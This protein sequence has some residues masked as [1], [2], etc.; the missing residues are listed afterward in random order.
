[1]KANKLKNG[2]LYYNEEHERVER[3]LGRVNTQRVWTSSHE[4]QAQA[5]RSNRLRIATPLEVSD[6]LQERESEP[7]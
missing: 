7:T 4:R 5:I 1:M 6:Y 3:V 2:S